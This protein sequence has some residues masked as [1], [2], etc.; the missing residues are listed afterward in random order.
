[1]NKK[2]L[3]GSIIA[4]CILVG[5]SFTSVVGYRSVASDVKAS[6]LF[7]IRS[8][9]AIDEES[10]DLSCD[11]LGSGNS[12]NL[13]IPERDDKIELIQKAIES[14]R[15]MDDKTFKRFVEIVVYHRNIDITL[16]KLLRS[17]PIKPVDYRIFQDFDSTNK[18]ETYAFTWCDTFICGNCISYE[19]VEC[20]ILL[21]FIIIGTIYTII[22]E[23]ILKIFPSI[24]YTGC[25]E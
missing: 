21:L 1:M 4:L 3:I 8:S 2:I 7:N 9:R 19:N 22:C 16:L 24:A 15:K 13:L 20:I 12:I 18:S 23:I 11:Y 14:I 6:P 17:E 10:E 25:S 5:V